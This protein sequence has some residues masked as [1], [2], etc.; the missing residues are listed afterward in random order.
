MTLITTKEQRNIT[1]SLKVEQQVEKL[2]FLIAYCET[3]CVYNWVISR[4][5]SIS[6]T[7]IK[8]SKKVLFKR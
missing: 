5:D 6:T 2:L 4:H 8:F 3:K 7:N 1:N